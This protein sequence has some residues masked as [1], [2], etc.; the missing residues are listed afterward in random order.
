MRVQRKVVLSLCLVCARRRARRRTRRRRRY[1][2][3]RRDL[4]MVMSIALT[5]GIWHSHSSTKDICPEEKPSDTVKQRPLSLS[6][7]F[8]IV[9]CRLGG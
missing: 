4:S 3:K 8:P 6:S 9:G 1:R 2:R 5:C 7:L